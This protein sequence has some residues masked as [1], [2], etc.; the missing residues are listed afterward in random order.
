VLP[1]PP[2]IRSVAPEPIDSEPTPGTALLEPVH[3]MSAGPATTCVPDP[4]TTRLPVPSRPTASSA[5]ADEPDSVKV[6]VPPF[7]ITAT[8]DD[9]GTT[10]VAQLEPTL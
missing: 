8:S 7:A 6:D 4:V 5:P 9:V 2:S 3:P 10:P 1:L